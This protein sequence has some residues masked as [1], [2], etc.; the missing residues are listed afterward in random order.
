MQTIEELV[1]PETVQLKW[2]IRSDREKGKREGER[3]R[4]KEEERGSAINKEKQK[5]GIILEHRNHGM[6]RQERA[7]GE[8]KGIGSNGT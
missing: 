7:I 4:E 2:L 6:R 8:K 3:E 5:R 1:T